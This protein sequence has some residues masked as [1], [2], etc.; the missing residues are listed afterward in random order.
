MT[1]EIRK[2]GRLAQWARDM[3]L[4]AFAAEVVELTATPAPEQRPCFSILAYTGGAVPLEEFGLSVV[5]DLAGLHSLSQRT[6]VLM[7]NDLSQIIGQGEAKVDALGLR[8]DGVVTAE[9]EGAARLL[10]NA[11]NGFKW[12][13]DIG[14]VVGRRQFLEAGQIITVNGRQISGPV[15]IARES[16]LYYVSFVAT[17]PDQASSAVVAAANNSA[18]PAGNP[19]VQIHKDPES[20]WMDIVKN[21]LG[22]D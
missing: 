8:I 15:V 12:Q 9:D 7:D 22:M 20:T 17:G 16:L 14:A 2:V 11:R 1:I 3:D 6:V 4:R 21:W 13:A 18:A 19:L 5:I 10:A